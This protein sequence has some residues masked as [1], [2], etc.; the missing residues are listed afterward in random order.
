MTPKEPLLPQKYT[1]A[2]I[3]KLK[4]DWT[5]KERASAYDMRIRD[6][7]AVRDLTFLE[8]G[9]LVLEFE[10]E[11]GQLARELGFSGFS[12]WMNSGRVKGSRSKRYAARAA[13]LSMIEINVQAEDG[14]ELPRGNAQVLA[15]VSKQNRQKLMEAAKTMEKREFL[16]H[17][18]KTLPD[19]HIEDDAPYRFKPTKSQRRTIDTAIQAALELEEL[20]TREEILELWASNYLEENQARIE[21]YYAEEA[22]V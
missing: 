2:V 11:E 6:I 16:R 17:I 5:P 22:S 8:V 19:E 4:R 13:M 1:P 15:K 14:Y 12:A 3:A 10:K 21:A 18:E 9:L 7:E 20:Q